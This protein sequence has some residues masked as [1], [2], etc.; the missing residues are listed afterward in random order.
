M[1]APC[2]RGTL[3]DTDTAQQQASLPEGGGFTVRRSRRERIGAANDAVD[4]IIRNGRDNVYFEV[5]SLAPLLVSA[6]STGI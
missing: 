5:S 2:F 3:C 6:Q 4:T 1:I